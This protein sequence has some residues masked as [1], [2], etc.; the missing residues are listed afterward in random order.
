MWSILVSYKLQVLQYAQKFSSCLVSYCFISIRFPSNYS[1][2][3]FFIFVIP[4][5]NNIFFILIF[6]FTYSR[7]LFLFIIILFNYFL[8]LTPLFILF[9][10][11]LLP[12]L[13]FPRYQHHLN[14]L[15]LSCSPSHHHQRP[16]VFI[17]PLDHS[18]QSVVCA[19]SHM[20]TTTCF[21]KSSSSLHVAE[22]LG[23]CLS[24]FFFSESIIH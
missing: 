9:L 20:I 15:S 18:T 16:S 23:G 14:N 21:E 13:P 4:V 22:V 11:Q 12:H 19:W 3:L 5:L 8:I 7:S 2:F 6:S 10:L 1:I 17:Y 24:F